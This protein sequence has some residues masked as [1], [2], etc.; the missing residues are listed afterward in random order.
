VLPEGRAAFV[1]V[2]RDFEFGMVGA[3]ASF[4]ELSPVQVRIFR[5]RDA[6]LGWLCMGE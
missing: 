6:A 2:L 1:V 5:A 3:M 4:M